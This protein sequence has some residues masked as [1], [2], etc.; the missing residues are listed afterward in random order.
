ME[1]H[2]PGYNYCGPGTRDMTRMPVNALDSCCRTHDLVYAASSSTYAR[3]R[4]DKKLA[5]CARSVLAKG[6]PG[7]KAAASL[8][9]AAMLTMPG[10]WYRG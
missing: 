2:I 4:A 6:T 3:L 7:E 8:V 5:D 1:V 9:L 10:A